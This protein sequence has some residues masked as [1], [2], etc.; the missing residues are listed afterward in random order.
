MENLKTKIE[1]LGFFAHS[2]ENGAIWYMRN[3]DRVTFELGDGFWKHEMHEEVENP[4]FLVISED[5]AIFRTYG[6]IIKQGFD[7]IEAM[8]PHVYKKM[9][10][11]RFVHT[12]QC[13]NCVN[14]DNISCKMPSIIG[15]GCSRVMLSDVSPKFYKLPIGGYDNPPRMFLFSSF[16]NGKDIS[17]GEYGKDKTPVYKYLDK[18]GNTLVKGIIKDSLTPFID[19][20]P[21]NCLDKINCELITNHYL[22]AA[23]QNT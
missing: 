14:G 17:W 4:I 9:D 10:L 16:D 13:L 21:E 5:K 22:N 8:I 23:L 12:Y 11:D 7:D 18:Y 2:F 19:V 6:S 20:Y 3:V 1:S 15:V